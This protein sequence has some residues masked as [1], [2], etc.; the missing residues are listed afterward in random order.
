[1]RSCNHYYY[2]CKCFIL[3]S[4]TNIFSFQFIILLVATAILDGSNWF[5]IYCK[6]APKFKMQIQKILL[7]T[8]DM[9]ESF[10]KERRSFC[11][12]FY[13][14]VMI[15]YTLP[16][17]LWHNLLQRQ[18]FRFYNSSPT[19]WGKK[20]NLLFTGTIHLS[21]FTGTIHCYYSLRIFAYLRGAVPYT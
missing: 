9:L 2:Y 13:T 12:I 18:D 10:Q 17:L 1:M 15:L 4:I 20:W 8:I 11:H 19:F 16:C 7:L 14:F 6:H 21:L 5:H 3:F